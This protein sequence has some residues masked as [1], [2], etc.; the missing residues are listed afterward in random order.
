M[1]RVGSYYHPKREQAR[2]LAERLQRA[3][4]ETVEVWTC[5][6]AAE[7]GLRES[8]AGTDLLITVGGDGTVLRAARA[9]AAHAARIVTVNMGRLGFLTE[10]SPEDV[11]D[12]LPEILDGGGRVEERMMLRASVD[13]SG[14]PSGPYDALND[15]VVGRGAIGRPADL[16]LVVDGQ[17]LAV[18]RA[19][20]VIVSTPTAST[21][22][23]LSAGGPILHPES[24][25]IVIVPVAAHLSRAHSFVLPGSSQVEVVL[26]GTEDGVVSVDGQVNLDLVGGSRVKISRSPHFARFLRLNPPTY[27]YENLARKLDL[28]AAQNGA[29]SSEATPR[30][31]AL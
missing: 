27:F 28:F 11:M 22:Y 13:T 31:H 17:T 10:L 29:Q 5:S 12:R 24:S 25:E 9:V 2:V 15:V 16:Q 26:Q 18:F 1:K 21:G 14:I 20:A 6:S 30:S 3:M 7:D 23:V 19:D 4:G 8:I